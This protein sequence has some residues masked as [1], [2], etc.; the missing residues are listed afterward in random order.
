[1]AKHSWGR[2]TLVVLALAARYE[3]EALDPIA[4]ARA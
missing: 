1:M 3:A 2:D 4:E